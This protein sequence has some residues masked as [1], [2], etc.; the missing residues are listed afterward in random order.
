MK[1]RIFIG[2]PI[3][4]A[5]QEKIDEWRKQYSN[6]PVKWLRGKNIHVTLLPPWY[7]EDI[8]KEKE[9]LHSFKGMGSFSLSF[10]RVEYGPPGRLI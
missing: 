3:S 10:Q 5:L 2:L 8:D 4:I 1:H 6:L 7:T 9:I